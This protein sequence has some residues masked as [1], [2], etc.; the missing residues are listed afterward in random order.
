M[1]VSKAVRKLERIGLV[2]TGRSASDNRAAN[3]QFV[4]KGRRSV[5]KV[6]E[7]VENIDE[8]F[9]SCLSKHQ[10]DEYKFLT[11][12]VIAEKAKQ[13]EILIN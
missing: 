13:S 2:Y 9:F 5:T 3:L 1:T 10:M 11:L 6:I 7:A 12:S 8:E 4:A